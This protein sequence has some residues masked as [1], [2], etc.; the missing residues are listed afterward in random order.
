M[1]SELTSVPNL[2]LTTACHTANFGEIK[3]EPKKYKSTSNNDFQMH[4]R[5]K[6]KKI[7]FF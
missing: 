3:G 2:E 4:F 6:K 5:E 7:T 1:E